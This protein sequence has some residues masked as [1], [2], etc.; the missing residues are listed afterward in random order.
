ML[1]RIRNKK[2]TIGIIGLGYVGLP[3]AVETAKAGFKVI[4]IDTDNKK[5]DKIKRGDSYVQDVSSS[6][7]NACVTQGLLDVST[8]YSMLRE[9]DIIDIAVPTPLSKSK[10]PDVSFIVKAMSGIKKHFVPNK[11]I[12]LEST[13]YPGTTRELVIGEMESSGYKL[14]KDFWA[15]F[16]PE[17]VDP[18]NP[19][20]RTQNTP[21]VIGGASQMSTELANAYYS[22]V[23]DKTIVVNS[24]EEAEMCKLLE[25]TFRAVNIG[26]INELT[27]MCDKMGI[28]IWS[29][30]DAAKTKPFGFMPFY[31]GPGIGGHC[32]PLDPMYLSWKAK[33]FGFFNRSIELASDINEN[34]PEFTVDKLLRI[35]NQRGKLLNGAK[36]LILGV[37]YK[38]DVDDVRESP[39]LT[40]HKKL[41]EFGAQVSYYDPYVNKFVDLDGNLVKSIPELSP[42][43]LN[44]ADAVMLVTAHNKFDYDFILEH[45]NL[46]FDTRNGFAHYNSDKIEVL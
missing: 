16:S 18:G 38:N 20:Y 5:V 40:I 17:R 32:I 4:G 7:L 21:K 22:K 14:D 1:D 28:N 12:I 39:A 37:A 19:V 23:V 10:T 46:I 26:F 11:L 27:M 24:C 15:A 41:F 29:V 44:A 30:I 25:N 43:I 35:M 42:D 34:M 6:D 33:H 13:T 9:V 45:S 36:V 31:P 3:L 2:A 8:D